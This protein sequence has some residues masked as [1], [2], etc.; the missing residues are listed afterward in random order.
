MSRVL[1]KQVLIYCHN[2][3]RL[4]WHQP[5]QA[6][7]WYDTH[8]HCGNSIVFWSGLLFCYRWKSGPMDQKSVAQRLKDTSYAKGKIYDFWTFLPV[9][10]LRN[11]L[12]K[13]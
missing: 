11:H 4:G 3:R 8:Y 9:I 10:Q 2:K 7:F 1:Q 6:F 5:T 13:S 12:L